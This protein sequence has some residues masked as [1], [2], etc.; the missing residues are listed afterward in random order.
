MTRSTVYHRY[1]QRLRGSTLRNTAESLKKIKMPYRR[2]F[3]KT[4]PISNYP[5]FQYLRHMKRKSRLMRLREGN[6]Y[7]LNTNSPVRMIQTGQFQS[8]GQTVYGFGHTVITVT[9]PGGTQDKLLPLEKLPTRKSLTYEELDHLPFEKRVSE[10]SLSYNN[11]VRPAGKEN[12]ISNKQAQGGYSAEDLFDLQFQEFKDQIVQNGLAQEDELEEY[13]NANRSFHHEHTHLIASHFGKLKTQEGQILSPF[14]K[15]STFVGTQHLNTEMM[16][17]E[18][19]V[20]F[21]LYVNHKKNGHP[22]HEKTV[23]YTCKVLFVEGTII[24]VGLQLKILDKHTGIEFVQTWDNPYQVTE[25]PSAQL[26]TALLQSL[27]TGLHRQYK[28]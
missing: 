16:L 19:F 21:L 4:D 11:L 23:D 22:A 15:E 17:F 28:A 24:P 5:N 3:Y 20:D 9:T 1:T 18:K 26:Y 12:R 8:P 10:V 6:F 14:D 7:H 27:K 25:K 13:L 2:P